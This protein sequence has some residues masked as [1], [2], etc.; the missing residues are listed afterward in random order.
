MKISKMIRIYNSNNQ[1]R[2]YNIIL[3]II[4]LYSTLIFKTMKVINMTYK[5]WYPLF[6]KY[7]I[8]KLSKNYNI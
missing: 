8:L 7:S 4:I 3:N 6:T 2:Y 5:L 1:L